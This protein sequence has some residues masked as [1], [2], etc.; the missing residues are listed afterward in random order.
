MHRFER[1]QGF[2][3]RFAGGATALLLTTMAVPAAAQCPGDCDG[4]G[5]VAINELIRGVNIALGNADVST[6]TAMDVD[7]SGTV[8]INELIQAV[9]AAL[10]GCP[11]PGTP[12]N[13]PTSTRTPTSTPTQVSESCGD[14]TVD[15]GE[16]CDDGKHCA[17][18]GNTNDPCEIDT[19]CDDSPDPGFCSTRSGDGCQATCAL[20]VCGDGVTDNLSGS[21]E[22]NVCVGPNSFAGTA[23][24]ENADCA[25][26]TC[27][28]G[29]TSE[30]PN[31]S[32]PANCRIASCDPSGE[33]IN[34]NVNF[35][36]PQGIVVTGLEYFLRYPD[37]VVSI[38]GSGTSPLVTLR[39][40]SDVFPSLTANDVNFG[41]NVVMFDSSLFGAESGTA[42]TIT[43]D[44]CGD[45]PVPSVGAF[46]CTL[47]AASDDALLDIT[48]QVDCVVA[49]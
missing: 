34:F 29:N 38:P 37:G 14:G 24:T 30:G 46:S 44:R 36:A 26:E 39:L 25:G 11:D 15:E 40:A 41:L 13:T 20:P 6:C 35:T 4:N 12:T 18:G 7:G 31:D 1:H 2:A 27:D 45:A 8:A 9:N 21:C 3:V 48:N 32:C 33:T 5:T 49:P 19:D 10:T 28:D 47:V 43:F 17:Q 22:G 16:E 42:M 23:C